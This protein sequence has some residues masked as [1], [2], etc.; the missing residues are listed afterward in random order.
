LDP[1][2]QQLALQHQAQMQQ[3]QALMQQLQ[4]LQQIVQQ[5]QLQV[6]F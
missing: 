3:H 1:L 6:K 4:L 2:L 5:Q